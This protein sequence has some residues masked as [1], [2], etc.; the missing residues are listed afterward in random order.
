[1]FDLSDSSKA[2]APKSEA[3]ASGGRHKQDRTRKAAHGDS[4]QNKLCCKGWILSNVSSGA[5]MADSPV[6]AA[7][8]CGVSST[9]Y[10]VIVSVF[11]FGEIA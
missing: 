9:C 10:S 8:W 4:S 3:P 11:L 2:W 5:A 7:V 1:M 6:T